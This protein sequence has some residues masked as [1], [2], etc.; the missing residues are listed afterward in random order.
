[1]VKRDYGAL[2]TIDITQ[3]IWINNFKNIGKSL[4]EYMEILVGI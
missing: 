3:P 1:M 4:F 2:K